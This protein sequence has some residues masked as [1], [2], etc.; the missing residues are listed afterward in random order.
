MRC[1]PAS[2]QRVVG[3][4]SELLASDQ[5]ARR[6]PIPEGVRADG[7]EVAPETLERLVEGQAA[8]RFREMPVAVPFTL[9]AHGAGALMAL[10][11]LV[12]ATASG[13]RGEALDH[14]TEAADPI[15]RGLLAEKDMSGV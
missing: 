14:A 7:V 12:G 11:P 5:F 2:N 10:R 4:E 9:L 15:V 8:G 13:A 6:I 3:F 1:C